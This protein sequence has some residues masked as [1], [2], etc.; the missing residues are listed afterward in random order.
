MNELAKLLLQAAPCMGQPDLIISLGPYTVYSI[1]A[2]LDDI[3]KK[4]T[5]H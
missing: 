5:V 3:A 2:T 1:Q 4:E